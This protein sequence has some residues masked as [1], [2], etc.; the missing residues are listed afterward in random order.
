MIMIDNLEAS[1]KPIIKIIIAS[2]VFSACHLTHFFSS[3][4]PFDLII[5]V[6]T[7]GIGI[8]LGLIYVYTESFMMCVIFHFLYN[9]INNN[10]ASWIKLSNDMLP[11]Y[12]INTAIGII[13]GAY[14]LVLYLL[15]FSKCSKKQI[16]NSKQE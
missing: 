12:L 13:V 16:P 14:L 9:S 10:L 11:Y 6:Y 1:E 15:K 7:Y 2:S 3:F 4:N 5:V 8:I